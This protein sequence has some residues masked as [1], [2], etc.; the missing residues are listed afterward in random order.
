MNLLSQYKGLDSEKFSGTVSGLAL[1]SGALPFPQEWNGTGL[2]EAIA[3]ILDFGGRVY[4][5]Q[6]NVD[7]EEKKA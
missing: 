1:S 7:T 6:K 4:R 3:V 2:H 5:F